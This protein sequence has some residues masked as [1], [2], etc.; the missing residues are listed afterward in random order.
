MRL[1]VFPHCRRDPLGA[2]TAIR[3][4]GLWPNTVLA[5][6]VAAMRAIQV[7][8]VRPAREVPRRRRDATA[9]GERTKAMASPT[10]SGI[11]IWPPVRMWLLWLDVVMTS[12]ATLA[13]LWIVESFSFSEDALAVFCVM[14]AAGTYFG[15]RAGAGAQ[16]N[17][18][19]DGGTR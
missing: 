15:V 6:T 14:L 7:S 8:E 19:T 9:R 13:L 5:C 17:R 11:R 16:C 18:P 4:N 1:R 10:R 12:L 2:L 3:P